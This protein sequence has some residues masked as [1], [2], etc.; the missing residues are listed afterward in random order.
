MLSNWLRQE[1]MLESKPG[2][3]GRLSGWWHPLKFLPRASLEVFLKR[4]WMQA[5]P[6]SKGHGSQLPV[7]GS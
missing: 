1:W 2:D 4:D 3:F 5:H 7:T 6:H